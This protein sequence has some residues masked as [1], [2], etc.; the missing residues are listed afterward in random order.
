MNQDR[1]RFLTEILGTETGY[2]PTYENKDGGR[3]TILRK[4]ETYEEAFHYVRHKRN[5]DAEQSWTSFNSWWKIGNLID[6]LRKRDDFTDVTIQQLLKKVITKS[7][8]DIP[9]RVA[10]AV[11]EYLKENKP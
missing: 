1:D 6:G 3:T 7:L 5:P 8:D 4:F 2:L 9:S 11:Y 10:D